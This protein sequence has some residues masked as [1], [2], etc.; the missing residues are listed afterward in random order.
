MAMYRSVI[1]ILFRE[2]AEKVFDV[3]FDI[4]K[5]HRYAKYCS[6]DHLNQVTATSGVNVQKEIGHQQDLSFKGR[7]SVGRI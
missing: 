1:L 7:K 4:L 2:P 3:E 6:Q 5:K